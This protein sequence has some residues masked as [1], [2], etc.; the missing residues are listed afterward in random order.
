MRVEQPPGLCV[1]RKCISGVGSRQQPFASRL[2]SSGDRTFRAQAVGMVRRLSV[3]WGA[4]LCGVHHSRRRKGQGIAACC[5]QRPERNGESQRRTSVRVSSFRPLG[6]MFLARR[7]CIWPHPRGPGTVASLRSCAENL[8]GDAGRAPGAVVAEEKRT[9]CGGRAARQRGEVKWGPRIPTRTFRLQS[10]ARPPGRESSHHMATPC[11]STRCT[12]PTATATRC[13]AGAACSPSLGR[14]ATPR[15]RVNS[16]SRRVLCSASLGLSASDAAAHASLAVV[17]D[18]S[19]TLF[20]LG[21][22]A[23]QL[24]NASLSD[25]T[26]V[27]YLIVLVR[28][29]PRLSSRFCGLAVRT[30]HTRTA[31]SPFCPPRAPAC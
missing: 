4:L 17:G 1:P 22:Q 30:S 18:L 31:V 3:C 6:D 29:P 28:A 24:V 10:V 25:V 13:C 12:L 16:S 19:T 21:Q 27:T 15:R 26:P 11:L 14:P 8:A 7:A 9:L 23:D 2:C 20:A 5:W